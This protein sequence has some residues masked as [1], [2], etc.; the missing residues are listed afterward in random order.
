MTAHKCFTFL[1]THPPCQCSV[2]ATYQCGNLSRFGQP[3]SLLW[4]VTSFM[5]GPQCKLRGSERGRLEEILFAREFMTVAAS[6]EG[7]GV[8]GSTKEFDQVA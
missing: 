7:R 3:P 8:Q 5:V 6:G 2:H 1:D 4:N